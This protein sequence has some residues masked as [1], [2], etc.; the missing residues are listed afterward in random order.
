MDRKTVEDV[1]FERISGSGDDDVR[2]TSFPSF[3]DELVESAG[4]DF[5]V[6]SENGDVLAG[7][8]EDFVDEMG[9]GALS[10]RAGDTDELHVTN[11]VTVVTREEF[12]AGALGTLFESRFFC[13]FIHSNSVLLRVL[14]HIW[15]KINYLLYSGKM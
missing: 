15:G 4:F 10:G 1:V 13:F 7:G 9:D 5:C 2:S 3:G 11:R 8:T 12:R 14:Y 6:R